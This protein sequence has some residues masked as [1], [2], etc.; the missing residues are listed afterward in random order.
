MAA[1]RAVPAEADLRRAVAAGPADPD[2]ADRRR[3][4]AL[5]KANDVIECR[6]SYCR[7]QGSIARP[8]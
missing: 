3:R 4:E 5:R 7:G 8:A 1:A 2:G 6:Q